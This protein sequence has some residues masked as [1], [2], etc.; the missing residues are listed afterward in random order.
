[1]PD[2]DRSL[3]PI[4]KDTSI[5]SRFVRVQAPMKPQDL[6]P[7]LE[8]YSGIDLS[9]EEDIFAKIDRLSQ[10]REREKGI[11]ISRAELEANRRYDAY[12]PL[13]PDME[14]F[15]AHGQAY[16]KKAVNGVLKGTSLAASTIAG[17][18]ATLGGLAIAPFTGRLADIWDNQAMRG[19][20]KLNTKID[21]EYLPNYY[22]A[23]ERDAKWYQAGNW[24][25]V[26]F[27]FDK[28]IKNAGFAVGAMYGGTIANVGLLKLGSVLGKGV[29]G[30]AASSQ[31]SQ[32]FK[33]FT[34]LLRNTARAF[35]AGKNIEAAAV[36]EKGISSIADITKGSSE[37]YKI[38]KTTQQI[39]RLSDATRRSVVALYSAAGESSFE[40]I[41]TVNEYKE[42]LVA[43]YEDEFGI[44]PT[45][46]ELMRIEK[47]ADSLGKK[48]FMG[49]LALLGI[50]EYAQLPYLVGSTYRT[51][52]S[53]ANTMMGKVD[54]VVLEGGKYI[55]KPRIPK[56]FGKVYDYARVGMYIF[57][58]K[59]AAQEIGQYALQVGV[60]NY[61]NKAKESNDAD[62]WVD[63]F[64]YGLIG[65]D[66]R[67]EGVGALVSK[68]GI[69]SGVLGGITGGLMQAGQKYEG[70]KI[71]AANTERFI[72]EID[73][74]PTFKEA[75]KD[76]LRAGN[77]GIVLQQDEQ[78]AVLT[79]DELEARDL[80]TDSIH[81]YLAPR[82]KYGRFD[83]IMED[84]KDLR[85]ASITEDGLS[86]LKQ[87]GFANINDTIESYHKR[88]NKLTDFASKI[89]DLYSSMTMRYS[90]ET[91]K[92]KEGKEVTDI[93]GNILRKYTPDVI[94]K[95]VYAAT[96]VYDY[97]IRIPQVS[98]PLISN[99]IVVSDILS[100]IITNN[101]PNKE[102]TLKAL[103][104]INKL[105]VI[106][107]V[108]TDLKKS[109]QDVIELSLRR[110]LFI[111][112]L[113]D[114]RTKP[115][116]YD[117][118]WDSYEEV[119]PPADVVQRGEEGKTTKKLN[120]GQEYS[121]DQLLRKEDNSLYLAPKLTVLSQTL[122]GEFE[123]RMPN[124][125]TQFL[126]PEEFE[127]FQITD[128]DNTR[129]DMAEMLDKTIDDVLK[130][131]EYGE[132]EKAPVTNKIAYIN[133]LDDKK[134]INDIYNEFE[135]RV[136]DFIKREQEVRKRKESLIKQKENLDKQQGKII[137][138]SGDPTDIPT[139]DDLAR[140]GKL[141]AANVLYIST[142]TESEGSSRQEWE[143]QDPTL[144]RP[145]I[146]RAR[147][148][149]NNAKNF[150]NRGDLRT[151][152]ITPKMAESLGLKG[153][154][155]MSFG[156]DSNTKLED[157][158]GA[159]Y[160]QDSKAVDVD[161]YFVASVFVEKDGNI[162][163]FINENGERIGKVGQQV[164][165][166][167]V[168]F[169]T[170]PTTSLTDSRG[171]PRYRGNQKAEAEAQHEAWKVKRQQLLSATKPEIYEFRVSRGIANEIVQEIEE[172]GTR[173]T[174]R[175]KNH[176]GGVLVP[177]DRI[178]TQ[179]G[180]IKVSTT[181]TVF[182]EP[183]GGVGENINIRPGLTVLT[184]DDTLEIL[185][186]TTLGQKRAKTIYNIIKALAQELEQ[187]GSINNAYATY[188]QHVLYWTATP[189]KD[190]QIFIDTATAE[191]V[192]GKTR[193]SITEINEKEAEIVA[194][195]KDTYHIV[196]N[197][198][199]TKNF[200]KRF[201]E[202]DENLNSV[203]WTNYQTYLL[204]SKDTTGKT[205]NTQET[206]LVTSIAK[207]TEAVP[208]T[209]RQKY[210]TL[211]GV[212]LPV[213]DIPVPPPAVEG[214]VKS[215]TFSKGPILY[216]ESIEDGK[217][218]IEV[219]NNS[220]LEAYVADD[221]AYNTILKEAKSL[222]PNIDLTSKE[223][224]RIDV[225]KPYFSKKIGAI[226][227]LER[228][229]AT[230]ETPSIK[231][232][233]LKNYFS[234]NSL[235]EAAKKFFKNFQSFQP[236]STALGLYSKNTGDN[237]EDL[238]Y[239]N[240]KDADRI[241]S[242]AK[243]PDETGYVTDKELI[244]NIKNE[245][246]KIADAELEALTKEQK[247]PI[248]PEPKKEGLN[249]KKFKPPRINPEYN[250]SRGNTDPELRS[251]YFTEGNTTT[252]REVL[253]KIAKSNH[254]LSKLAKSL[255]KYTTGKEIRLIENN[256]VG[257]TK[258]GTPAA[259]ANY[260]Q[261]IEIA[262]LARF[263]G[264]GAEPT[265]LHEIIHGLTSEYINDLGKGSREYK[266]FE[267]LFNEVKS[268]MEG[269]WYALTNMDEFIV[270]LFTDASFIN[271]LQKLESN[272]PTEFKNLLQ[273]IFDYILS[274]FGIKSSNSIYK[275]AFAVATNILEEAHLAREITDESFRPSNYDRQ[276]APIAGIS[277]K[278]AYEFVDD[279]IV[280]SFMYIFGDDKLSI[281]DIS[282]MTSSELFD[283]IKE[284]YIYE[285]KY[286]EDIWPQLVK[287][288]KEKLRTIG[289]DFQGENSINDE[290]TN[291]RD[292]APEAFTTDWKK[293][294]PFA[295]KI[296]VAT[297]Y[298]TM[299]TNQQNDNSMSLPEAKLSGEG[300]GFVSV[301]FSKVFSVLMN[302]LANTTEV[303]NIEKKLVELA[304]SD[305]N[306]VRL[307]T[308]L[309]GNRNSTTIDFDKFGNDEWRLFVNFYQTFTKQKPEVLIQ[310]ISGNTV[311]SRKADIFSA[312]E[313]AK[314]EWIEELKVRSSDP[315]SYI[316]FDRKSKTYKFNTKNSNFPKSVPKSATDAIKFLND[317][318]IDFTNEMFAKLK[319]KTQRG[320]RTEQRQFFDAVSAIHT[321]L[322]E[323]T[324]LVTI[325]SGSLQMSGGFNT[326]A[327]IIVKITNT[328]QE[329]TRFNLEGNR[330]QN[331]ENNNAISIF[332]NEFNDSET[333]QELKEKRTELNDLFSENS[334]IL[335][336]G[337]LFFDNTGKRTKRNM[338]VGVIE[339]QRDDVSGKG[340]KIS[341]VN[342]GDRNVMMINQ[343]LNGNYY[344]LVPADA[345][346]E[347]MLNMGNH[348]HFEDM[349]DPKRKWKDI[350]NIFHGYLTDDIALAIDWKNRNRLKNVSSK[351]VKELRFFKDI[352]SDR[353]A[354]G[355]LSPSKILQGLDL[356]IQQ[357]KPLA[358]INQ[359]VSDNLTKI[360][361]YIQGFINEINRNTRQA[362]VDQGKLTPIVVN[363]QQLYIFKELDSTFIED[364]K[365]DKERLTDE[366]IDN[367]LTYVNAN[368]AINNIEFYKTIFGDP[369]AISVDRVKSF[370]SPARTTFD[371]P[372]YNSWL[373][374][375]YNKVGDTSLEEEELGHHTFKSYVSTATFSDVML[376][377]NTYE[378][379]NET[380]SF[381]FL[382]DNTYRE[383]KL[384]NGQWDSKAEQWHQWQM[385]YTRQNL[386]GYVY[387]NEKLR[388]HDVKMLQSP[389]PK[390]VI[391]V[392]KPIVRGVV[393]NA[394]EIHSVLDKFAQMPL[395]YKAAKDRN[396]GHLYEKMWKEKIGYA[397][398]EKGRKVGATDTNNLYNPDGSLNTE[399]FT[400]IIEV[401]W[402]AYGIQVETSYDKPK[403]QTR[404]SQ[405][406][407]L[408][409]LDLFRYGKPISENAGNAYARN[410]RALKLYHEHAYQRL[411]VKLG[412]ED[413]GNHYTLNPEVIEDTLTHEMLRREMSENAIDT[414]QRDENG[415]FRIPFEA[416]SAY[417]SIKDILYSVVNKSLISPKMS[418]G[419]KVQVPVTLWEQVSEGRDIV[420]KDGDRYKKIT[421]DEYNSL[422]EEDK[423]K[424]RLTSSTLKTYEDEDGKR[425]M[426]IMIPQWFKSKFRNRFKDDKQLLKYLNTPEGRKI[427]TGIGFRIPT[428]A[429]ASIEVFVVKDFLPAFMGD[430]VV[431][432]SDITAKTGS[433]FDIDKLNM[434]LKSIYVDVKGNIRL[435][436]YK[437][438][439]EATKQFYSDNYT[440][441]IGSKLAQIEKHSEF[442]RKLH[443]ILTKMEFMPS[444]KFENAE[445][446]VALSREDLNFYDRYQDLIDEIIEQADSKN[447]LPS[448]YVQEQIDRAGQNEYRLTIE[449]LDNSLRDEY[450]NNM[451]KKSLE[452]EYYESLEEMITLPE[453][454]QRLVMPIDEKGLKPVAQKLNKLRGVKDNIRNKHLDRDYMAK[455]RHAYVSAKNW[456]GIAAVNITGTSLF[457][458][459]N[460]YLDQ[461]RI[462]GL[463]KFE[464]NIIKDGNILLPHNKDEQGRVSLSGDMNVDGQYISDRLS[465][466]ITSF[467]DVKKDPYVMEIVHSEN[468]VNTFM[469]LERIGAGETGVMFMNQ[470]I[471]VE[472]LKHLANIGTKGLFGK[473]NLSYIRSRFEGPTVEFNPSNFES[474]IEAY[475]QGELTEQQKG[476]QLAILDEFLKYAMMAKYLSRI[477]QA[478]NYDTTKF[479]GS[480]SFD[481]KMSKTEIA[482]QQNIFANVDQIF[483]QSFIGDQ[484]DALSDALNSMSAVLKFEQSE[485][486]EITNEII[487]PYQR[488]EFMRADEFDRIAAKLK[489]SFFDYIVQTKLGLNSR[490][491]ELLIDPQ[492]SVATRLTKA[493]DKYPTL[494]ILNYLI[495]ESRERG[496]NHE[497]AV[498]TI[499]LRV[500][501]KNAYDENLFTG[502][503]RELR[504][505][506]RALY[507]D[508]I[509]V[510]I[511]QGSYQSSVS[512]KNIIPIEDYSAKIKPIIDSL[513][514]NPDVDSF[515]DGWFQRN[516][517]RDDAIVP[518]YTPKLFA[519]DDYF[520]VDAYGNDITSYEMYAFK[521]AIPL[522]NSLKVPKERMYRNRSILL[523]NE[524]Y[525]S[526]TT[527]YDF[528]KIPRLIQAGSEKIDLLTGKSV[529]KMMERSKI[530]KGDFSYYTWFGYQKVKYNNGEAV[531]TLKGEHIYKLINLYGDGQYAS[532]YYDSFRESVIDNG[533]VK[534]EQEILDESIIDYYGGDLEV[535]DD[536]IQDEPFKML[537][538][539]VKKIKEGTKTIT[540]RTQ[541]FPNGIYTL[542][543][544]T[545]INLKYRGVYSVV[546]DTSLMNRDD[547]SIMSKD[548]FARAEGFENWEDF[549]SK[550]FF[551]AKFIQGQEARY[552]Y[553]VSIH[554]QVK[555]ETPYVR[556]RQVLESLVNRF[557]EANFNKMLYNILPT[558]LTIENNDDSWLIHD[559]ATIIEF[560]EQYRDSQEDLGDLTFTVWSE[561]GMTEV[562]EFSLEGLLEYL[563]PEM[564][565]IRPTLFDKSQLEIPFGQQE[566]VV[567]QQ[568]LQ[569]GTI[570]RFVLKDG[571]PIEGYYTQM[572][573]EEKPLNPKNIV[574]KYADLTSEPGIVEDEEEEVSILETR[575]QPLSYTEGQRNALLDIQDMI[576][577]N[578][579]GY[580]L[581]AGYAGT[582]KTTVVENIA[583]YARAKGREAIIMAPTNKAV[584]VLH[585]KLKATGTP[586]AA[587]TIHRAI[588]GEPDPV[589]GEWIPKTRLANSVIIIDESSMITTDVMT[590]LLENTTSNNIVILMGDRFQLEPVGK[591]PEL[592]TGK[593]KEF[594]DNRTELTEVKRQSLDSN[595]LKVATL[596]RTDNKAYIPS[597][598]MQDFKVVSSKTDFV[599]DYK[600]SI[601]KNEDS[602]MIVATNNERVAMNTIARNEKFGAN[603]GIIEDGEVI[604]S[605]ANSSEY[606]NSETFKVS[607][608]I[609]DPVLHDL[610]FTFPNNQSRKYEMYVSEVSDE[611]GIRSKLF[612]FPTLDRPSLYHSQILEAIQQSDRDLY[613]EL[614][615]GVD[616]IHKRRGASKLSPSIVIGTY[617]YAITAHKSQGSQWNKVFVNQNYVAPTWNGARWW[618][619]AITRSAAEVVAYPNKSNTRIDPTEI[620]N[621]INNI[622]TPEDTS[623]AI[624]SSKGQ[625]IGDFYKS[626]TTDQQKKL[627]S[628]ENL[629]NE[630]SQIPF[631]FTHQEFIEELNCRL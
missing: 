400:G 367:L 556:E 463:P 308:R 50:T 126:T 629:M 301:N 90:G 172:D 84:I 323:T 222:I 321:Y 97:D 531:T 42:N 457:Q 420:I 120:I 487:A 328:N 524:N 200:S 376:V 462:N 354:D 175:E 180:L 631:T 585:D 521:N 236:E 333:I 294:S 266:E 186:N 70:R 6:G 7:G 403:E 584:K 211:V 57:D 285:E 438:S 148:F 553:D 512:I 194:K 303:A 455:L 520:A 453:N 300:Q 382:I 410:M 588:Y 133:S 530:L 244:E 373:N 207:P 415:E 513:A 604:I 79:G 233:E 8:E 281:F 61:Y 480:E 156:V 127:K 439:E 258:D 214:D 111:D 359:Y 600:E 53:A 257:L 385:A 102:A 434:Y 80:K 239:L 208:Y 505:V 374:R 145:H 254:P 596:V 544:G 29:S 559:Y 375:E 183:A 125:K 312:T 449:L 169:Q 238:K 55:K 500:N 394:S 619:T 361:E 433:D 409:S 332:E 484:I 135:S 464:R 28:L 501:I 45:G 160:E 87:Q 543:D 259:A 279:M 245:A 414:L 282:K 123:V 88:L 291:N 206:P 72:E 352:L 178:S 550:E 27:L 251:K 30:L 526:S 475:Y 622:I 466:Y 277:E 602:V 155:Q 149:L 547:Q 62:Y 261:W 454:Y 603:K 23:Q 402:K 270:E 228:K 325:T 597:K 452:N 364:N 532:E 144:S 124:G 17:G 16:W 570:Y 117:T 1:M 384:K 21:Q 268:K 485:L 189:E 154:V 406:T 496:V 129:Q 75:F 498:K 12:S 528:I 250:I 460:I 176:V 356:L 267:R 592:F 566:E 613:D 67:G 479:R 396:L 9:G 78:D 296:V 240:R 383:I 545:Q 510:A 76:K 488:E 443:E 302:N 540:N 202:Y 621:K 119:Q 221:T 514:T 47:E 66:E 404:G 483:E 398:S 623:S 519:D 411:L 74:A 335:K 476:E 608:V 185:T 579:Q 578:K 280:R 46:E 340:T 243:H 549:K 419:P 237:V 142:I 203:E 616:I 81:N 197:R 65:K 330:T 167:S 193:Y 507:N 54:N 515:G 509:N 474:N 114:V 157:I 327:E 391:E 147:V 306:Y 5:P 612:I 503:M 191:I 217:L 103:D 427:L 516:N 150:D 137:Q 380:D 92:D 174:V 599:N 401:P 106:P 290:N 392:L 595:V 413:M 248:P 561:D 372:A 536:T 440:A 104:V 473:A 363:D 109:L 130:R 136:A 444:D 430:T 108:K 19:L 368:Y 393:N 89:G 581:L 482:E 182:H 630:Y 467:V 212:E 115:L 350:L 465:A 573:Q 162:L 297:L 399:P 477:S 378:D 320:G 223:V 338:K 128:L 576:E 508:I 113:N 337:G 583:N 370:L 134:L 116:N 347:W 568:F 628:L 234:L 537:P 461:E 529:T 495:P 435:I 555:K 161:N 299:A 216:T 610:T 598:S 177:E 18:F 343:N 159:L 276:F 34:P 489:N 563:K 554:E 22:T 201:I 273:E 459:T 502:M 360:D 241:I 2:F 171:N 577:Q 220:T 91:L 468:V 326:M 504:E 339:G 112:E 491:Y 469:L 284:D 421:R 59:E 594:R 493:K 572:G 43:K 73:E 289:I 617:G 132:L 151:M 546:N 565:K 518:V 523:V 412:I 470:P 346:T 33:A 41:Q 567:N 195:L 580:Y 64:L 192:L 255:M 395:Y 100:D 365:I 522:L 199:L 13:I 405:L 68:E 571:K 331:F 118:H 560:I 506:D 143:N 96:K 574:S 541:R 63:G 533:T 105:D 456:I 620:E 564:I 478:I 377:T 122:G 86:E 293:Y 497:E 232:E 298:E 31:S 527:N 334:V 69:E 60:Q 274:L 152:L 408:A 56:K 179:E 311:T 25:K 407:K 627:G 219:I 131:P 163:Y 319:T 446:I 98:A 210:A 288:T 362:L 101:K 486:R 95:M 593:V 71:K 82:I 230:E 309:G 436:T 432:P 272:Q 431:V 397:I 538:A 83:M 379:I 422:S 205:R 51:S 318:G 317:L 428:Q 322:Q 224:K 4:T 558:E 153:I 260:P 314:R 196:N 295:V 35:S 324:D 110:K 490:I 366:Q 357:D 32:A 48:S 542:K 278:L 534:V 445:D 304:N 511:L 341:R 252:D 20:D 525:D 315:K 618:Y 263:R 36:L 242:S 3:N 10:S 164:D 227:Q 517:F 423:K 209:H 424:V 388:A 218:V 187:K 15:A 140:E 287:R 173:I 429:M 37:L 93:N 369:Y 265:L 499:K 85:D 168:V 170:M 39:A 575:S 166:N 225:L 492:T 442:R 11:P 371:S 481:K 14:D 358:E 26:N 158:P 458:K 625:T 313:Q 539:N 586:V 416:S 271:G 472:Y 450:V 447:L 351:N 107:D 256:N 494:A 345:S 38:A 305:P 316:T 226:L 607:E 587:T 292:Y 548:D 611:N 139:E 310:Y 355:N 441:V 348:I 389:E 418:G 626:L 213:A 44:R 552:V 165:L 215:R 336:P 589:T 198:T 262:E 381:S 121:L 247:P 229:K 190:N 264:L 188:L 591:D 253:S 390:H 138:E 387:K 141:K 557:S 275:D 184:Y 342:I 231:Q 624:S 569:Y 353:D 426:E 609:S 386:P 94:D 40:T 49:N 344:V 146:K 249:T 235:K 246:F 606:A 451:Y 425:Y 437:G 58:P 590:D 24:F 286:D 269:N 614:D 471:I 601:R 283:K 77:R 582:G 349:S 52:R 448:E 329:N 204:S 307:F 99:G 181:K 605:V 535:S 417:K 562:H 615:N 551:S